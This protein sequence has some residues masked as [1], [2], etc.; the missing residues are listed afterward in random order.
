MSVLSTTEPS[1]VSIEKLE[2]LNS[3]WEDFTPQQIIS[4][5]YELFHGEKALSLS[6]QLEGLVILDMLLKEELT[7]FFYTIDTGRLPHETYQIMDTVRFKYNIPLQVFFPE[8]PSIEALVSQK[9]MFSFKESIANRKEC[10][11]LRKVE[12]NQR[13]LKGKEVWITGIRRD[14]S[15]ERNQTK[16]IDYIADKKIYKLAPLANWNWEQ[17]TSYAK[18]NQVPIHSLYKKGYTSIGCAPCTRPVQK[19]EEERSGRWWWESGTKECG[20]HL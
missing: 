2:E 13:A 9:G 8:H 18:S 16:I 3:R 20:L 17:V 11:H 7:A 14:Q 1:I 19:G 12:P 5:A 6:M 10:C 15:Q 4:S